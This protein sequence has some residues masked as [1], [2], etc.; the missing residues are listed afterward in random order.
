VKEN[1]YLIVEESCEGMFAVFGPFIG[2]DCAKS[3]AL[4]LSIKEERPYNSYSVYAA[5][6][7]DDKE[8]GSHAY[9]TFCDGNTYEG[10]N[11]QWAG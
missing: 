3:K 10:Q 7:E 6:E 8:M 1:A 11:G 2:L 9:A 4:E 5:R